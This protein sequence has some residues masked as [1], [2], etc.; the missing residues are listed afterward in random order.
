MQLL[1]ARFVEALSQRFPIEDK[2]ELEWIL[3]IKVTRDRVARTLT[4]SQALY[5]SDMSQRFQSCTPATNSRNFDSPMDDV[6]VLSPEDS[7]VINSP[8][9]V[10]MTP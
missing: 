7:P 5:V 2:G 4:M 8:E 10:E 3:N 1:R 6:L 9:W